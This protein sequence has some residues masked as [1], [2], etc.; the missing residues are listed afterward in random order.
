VPGVLRNTCEFSCSKSNSQHTRFNLKVN[1][2]LVGCGLCI[3]SVSLHFDLRVDRKCEPRSAISIAFLSGSTTCFA[4]N[5]ECR[6]RFTNCSVF[7]A[8]DIFYFDVFNILGCCYFILF[9][10]ASLKGLK[11][12]NAKILTG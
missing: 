11:K 12:I 7:R 1:L 8:P 3:G 10:S 9:F 5:W 6:L 2:V 4:K